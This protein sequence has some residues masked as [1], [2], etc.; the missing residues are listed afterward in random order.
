MTGTSRVDDILREVIGRFE[1]SFPGRLRACY[2]EGSYAD[3]SA[4]TTSDVDVTIVFRDTFRGAAEREAVEHLCASCAE[5]SEIEL[6][7]GVIDEAQLRAGVFPS[8]RHVGL[9]I[10]GEDVREAMRVL[11]MEEW[12]RN[13]MHAAYWLITHLFGRD[14]AGHLPLD[15]PDRSASFFGYDSRRV[16]LPNGTE[17][18]STRDL[19]RATGW[20]A[21]A[22]IALEAGAYVARKRDCHTTYQRLI[23]DEFADLLR[24]IYDNCR[25]RWQYLVPEAASERERLRALCTQTLS[26]ENAFLARYKRYLLNELECTK[27]D[28][29]DAALEMQRRTPFHDTDIRAAVVRAADRPH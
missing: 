20:A 19:I 27:A 5:T 16:R 12:T 13:R 29:C 24:D 1:T 18:P 28:A 26:F 17:T 11:P 3:G 15:Y 9:L 22:L 10:Y 7:I 4:V 21:T 2:A 23:G 6:D 25:I 8:L 14:G